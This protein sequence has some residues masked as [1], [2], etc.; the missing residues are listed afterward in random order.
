[1]LIIYACRVHVKK[2]FSEYLTYGRILSF[3]H[4]AW[5]PAGGGVP[6]ACPDAFGNRFHGNHSHG[7]V[8]ETHLLP[9]LF[10][11]YLVDTIS[12]IHAMVNASRQ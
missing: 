10:W 2:I 9:S 6:M 4:I 3:S 7:N 12:K 8:W 1:M 5:V 11:E